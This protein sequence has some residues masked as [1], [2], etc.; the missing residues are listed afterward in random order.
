M[1]PLKL[2]RSFVD[3]SCKSIELVYNRQIACSQ[4]AIYIILRI[5][6]MASEVLFFLYILFLEIDLLYDYMIN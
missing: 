5:I 4:V 1:V 6:E 2:L 3:D